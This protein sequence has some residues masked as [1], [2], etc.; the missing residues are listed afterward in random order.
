MLQ[1]DLKD[2][3]PSIDVVEKQQIRVDTKQI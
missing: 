1:I 3:I 2:F